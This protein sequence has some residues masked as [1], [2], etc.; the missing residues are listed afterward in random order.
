VA[1]GFFARVHKDPSLQEIGDRIYGHALRRIMEHIKD[2]SIVDSCSVSTGPLCLS[3][4]ELVRASSSLG[5][6]QH[7][8]GTAALVSLLYPVDVK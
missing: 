5:W 8:S 4:Y 6:A 7:S 1:V 3:I 2:A